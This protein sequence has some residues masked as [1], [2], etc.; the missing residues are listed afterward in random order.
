MARPKK[1]FD[2]KTLQDLCTI[3]C[4]LSEIASMMDTKIETLSRNYG[5]QIKKWQ[6]GGKSSLRRVQWKKAMEGNV[7]MLIW[8]GKHLLGQRDV[9][10]LTT[11]QPEVKKLLDYWETAK[12]ES[13]SSW[14]KKVEWGKKL[15]GEEL[16]EAV[17]EVPCKP[18][19]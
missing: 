10:E 6:E 17:V 9:V 15:R 14:Q 3:Q 5:E 7:P 16:A 2:M 8:L 1:K 18:T 12:V 4:T 11:N 13:K 19:P